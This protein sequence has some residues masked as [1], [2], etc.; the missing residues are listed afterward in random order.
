MICLQRFAVCEMHKRPEKISKVIIHFMNSNII[1]INRG[2]ME[3][4][5]AKENSKAVM[6]I[7]MDQN[8]TAT[9]AQDLKEYAFILSNSLGYNTNQ[10]LE[11]MTRHDLNHL[12]RTFK[13]YFND[14]VELRDGD[15]V[16]IQEDRK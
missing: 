10:I 12:I 14:Y 8:D 7:F 15:Q 2:T 5:S 6:R 4:L 13:K 9:V 3:N 1:A 16:V 11:E